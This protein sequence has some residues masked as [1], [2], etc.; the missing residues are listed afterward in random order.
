MINNKMLHAIF[1]MIGFWLI[2]FV[3]VVFTE[4]TDPSNLALTSTVYMLIVSI[5]VVIFGYMMKINSRLDILATKFE[6]VENTINKMT[7]VVVK[8]NNGDMD[9]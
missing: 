7:D 8:N 5:L 3:L 6:N 9:D 2:A 4:K 1:A